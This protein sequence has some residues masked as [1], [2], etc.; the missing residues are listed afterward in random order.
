MENGRS[1]N[2]IPKLAQNKQT[3]EHNDKMLSRTSF[4]F[5]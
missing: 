2:D 4:S 3:K 5:Q 1:D